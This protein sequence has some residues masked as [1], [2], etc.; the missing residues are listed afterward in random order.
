MLK[1]PKSLFLFEFGIVFGVA[2]IDG[3]C[4]IN[5]GGCSHD[6][7]QLTPETYAC[8][9]P[10]CWTMG[11]DK[12]TCYPAPE[13]IST[14]CGPK[15]M[16]ITMDKC[17][18]DESTHD[19]TQ[20]GMNGDSECVF[21]EDET[22]RS[23]STVILRNGLDEC[24]MS[25]S[26]TEDA[27]TYSNTL[28]VKSKRNGF[29]FTQANIEWSFKCSYETEYA[30]DELI[31]LNAASSSHG[32]IQT[33]AQFAFSFNFYTDESFTE[34]I[35]AVPPQY[36][37]GRNVNFGLMM[38]D[39]EPLSSVHFVAS[40]CEVTNGD[41]TFVIFDMN[42]PDHC[43]RAPPVFFEQHKN[44]SSNPAVSFY[45]YMGFTFIDE[46]GSST[47]QRLSCN[48]NVCHEDDADSV[49][50]SGCYNPAGVTMQ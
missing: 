49:C 3:S 24:G 36:Q 39:G 26:F 27:L 45:S 17:V 20:A 11:E 18:L 5:N 14:V 30:I 29:I 4:S 7:N 12:V 15:E 1:L 34:E 32:F 48:I 50:N 38:N 47:S 6:C 8:N 28:H 22:D 43:L 10:T 31:N 19:W 16:V 2:I 41:M 35:E 42:N 44:I 37:V 9:C 25:L 21:V 33:N 40:K 23:G 13:K 46:T